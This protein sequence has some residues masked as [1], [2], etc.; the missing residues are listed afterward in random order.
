MSIYDIG[1]EAE[2][3]RVY[4]RL[5]NQCRP[6]CKKYTDERI[7]CTFD[8]PVCGRQVEFNGEYKCDQCDYGH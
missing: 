2:E 1:T 7:T 5:H 6:S 4:R 8:C 3:K